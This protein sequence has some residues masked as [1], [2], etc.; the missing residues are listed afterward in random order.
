MPL[1][2]RIKA[3]AEDLYICPLEMQAMMFGRA[4]LPLPMHSWEALGDLRS[5]LELAP[6]D[7]AEEFPRETL[8]RDESPSGLKEFHS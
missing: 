7:M 1:L 3:A 2:P 8:R 5:V 6:Q 4:C